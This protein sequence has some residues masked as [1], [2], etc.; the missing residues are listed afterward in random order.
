MQE[1]AL[2]EHP[3]GKLSTFVELQEVALL[4][5]DTD[6]PGYFPPILGLFWA[7]L[8]Y[9]RLNPGYIPPMHGHIVMHCWCPVATVRNMRVYPNVAT[10]INVRVYHNVASQ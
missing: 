8:D 2:L 3:T 7:I 4:E 1:V 6:N 9:L 10:V 5:P